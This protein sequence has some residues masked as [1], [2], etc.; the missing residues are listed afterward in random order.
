MYQIDLNCDLGESYGRY[1]LGS[2]SEIIPLLSSANV[3]CGFHASD[4][5]VM[6]K[7]VAMAKKAG[8]GIGVHPGFPDHMGFGR[9]RMMLTHE[10]AK[11][12]VTYQIGALYG[13]CKSQGVKIQ[14]VKPH[15][16]FNNMASEDYSLARA[17]A[18]AIYEFDSS[19]IFLALAGSQ[20]VKAARDVGLR[21][22]CEAFADRAYDDQGM[23]VSRA[24]EGSM[25]HDE[26]VAVERIVRMI[27][28]GKV[29]TI[30]GHDID[31]QADSIC[32]H[33]DGPRALETVRGLRERLTAEGITICP[34]GEFVAGNI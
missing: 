28:E 30:T 26:H 19:I 27:K 1:T 10:E 11:T 34:M 29:K 22:A 9:R 33:G 17:V 13:F 6:E 25:I 24:L 16:A 14:H 31:I 20:M 7:T 8:I 15:G 23:L 3:A 4:P 2:D 32:V 5:V 12:Y 21:V 18:E